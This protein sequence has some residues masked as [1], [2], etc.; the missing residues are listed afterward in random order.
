MGDGFRASRVSE[1]VCLRLIEVTALLRPPLALLSP[2]MVRKVRR[3]ARQPVPTVAV[4]EPQAVKEL[5]RV[6]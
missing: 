6:A 4:M 2:A 1:E 3:A 5:E